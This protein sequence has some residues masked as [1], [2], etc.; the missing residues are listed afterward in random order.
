MNDNFSSWMA[1]LPSMEQLNFGQAYTANRGQ[2]GYLRGVPEGIGPSQVP[3]LWMAFA[4]QGEALINKEALA[5]W[6]GTQASVATSRRDLERSLLNAYQSA[7]MDP[8]MAEKELGESR[9]GTAMG[10]QEARGN[11]EANRLSDIF[12]LRSGLTSALGQSYLGDRQQLLEL[13]LAS[14]GRKTA[15]EGA[16]SALTS[17]L[18]GAGIGALGEFA[19]SAFGQGGT[20]GQT[21]PD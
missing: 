17:S 6:K 16:K 7:G 9:P 12:G 21:I 13:Y 20:F 10:L 1:S 14:M 8:L 3:A 2:P 11:I 4:P 19:G 15:R 5:R 18:L